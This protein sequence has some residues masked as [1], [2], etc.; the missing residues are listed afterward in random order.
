MRDRGK[1]GSKTAPLLKVSQ[2]RGVRRGDI[3]RN[4]VRTAPG[5]ES[6]DESRQVALRV[7]IPIGTDVDP[8]RNAEATSRQACKPG[9]NRVE[10][11]AVQPVAVD[12]GSVLRQPEN[13][14]PWVSSLR[15]LASGHGFTMWNE[16]LDFLSRKRNPD[17][18]PMVQS[19]RPMANNW[20]IDAW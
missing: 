9:E 19:G 4:I 3:D 2:A 14:W 10:A 16:A 7:T 12:D 13:A 15:M 17:L 20:L 18:P 1:Q 5:L 8:K 11:V 6:R